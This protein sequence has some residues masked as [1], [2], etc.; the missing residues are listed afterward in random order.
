MIILVLVFIAGIAAG[1]IN[2]IAG[3]GSMLTL[4]LLISSGIESSVAN[5][6]NRVAILAQNIFAI[7]GFK[8][9]GY[10]IK[11][12]HII[13]GLCAAVGALLGS[14]LAVDT[15]DS[16]FNKILAIL[17]VLFIIYSLLKPKYNNLIEDIKPN[18][19]ILNCIVFFFI[20]IYGGF[21][22]AG[23]GLII[24]GSL[25]IINQL[26]IHKINSIKVVVV[27][28]YT[29]IA[30]GTFIY[31]DQ[32]SWTHGLILAAGNSVGGYIAGKYS[33]IIPEQYVRRAVLFITIGLAIK[34]WL[35]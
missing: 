27:A 4:P 8:S 6:S 22:Q 25:S 32:I 31:F 19:L 18:K 14:M 15:D 35:I 23:V 10:K 2:V 33:L 7:K 34:L 1:F 13:L 3:G 11:K 17:L 24:M 28:V 21:I 26:N 5:G 20:G 30:L 16:L 12:A 29:V 9:N